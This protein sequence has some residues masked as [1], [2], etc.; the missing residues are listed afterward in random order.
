M[1]HNSPARWNCHRFT[2]PNLDQNSPTPQNDM[3]I[4]GLLGANDFFSSFFLLWISFFSFFFFF[5]MFTLNGITLTGDWPVGVWNCHS[6]VK[7]YSIQVSDSDDTYCFAKITCCRFLLLCIWFYRI[8]VCGSFWHLY[9]RC[10]SAY[11]ATCYITII[12]S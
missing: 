3:H 7:T 2:E 5:N 9:N 4:G 10:C 1:L 11:V 12:F 8:L 6:S